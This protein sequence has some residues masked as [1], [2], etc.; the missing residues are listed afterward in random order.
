MQ[1]R[2]VS[3]VGHTSRSLND[4]RTF[5]FNFQ[6]SFFREVLRR[7][8]REDE[9]RVVF[10]GGHSVGAYTCLQMLDSLSP[11]SLSSSPSN[12]AALAAAAAAADLARIKRVFMLF[13]T[14]SDIAS[15]PNGRTHTPVLEHLRPLVL[16]VV[17]LVGL[18]PSSLARLALVKAVGLHPYEVEAASALLGAQGQGQGPATV[19][20]CLHMARDEMRQIRELQVELVRRN[21][22]RLY[23][24]WGQRDSWAPLSQLAKLRELFG[25]ALR[26]E[27]AHPDAAHAFV[28]GGAHLV[29]PVIVEQMRPYL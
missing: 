1:F 29:A 13:P 8:L 9:R 6:L 4:G 26:F 7:A 17:R 27:R 10:L 15:T 5:P 18:L 2:V 20:C 16:G 22:A 25:T 19:A 14:I 11:S 3:F 24:V 28:V 21:L 23:F 12:A